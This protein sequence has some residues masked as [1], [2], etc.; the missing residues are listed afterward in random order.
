MAG[1]HDHARDAA[2]ATVAKRKLALTVS[3]DESDRQ[4]SGSASRQTG[5]LLAASTDSDSA[6]KEGC[7]GAGREIPVP[8]VE[9]VSEE[10]DGAAGSRRRDRSPARTL[11]SLSL[12]LSPAGDLPIRPRQSGVRSHP[13]A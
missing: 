3:G 8:S 4:L 12:S 6:R 1:D 7:L 11:R 5:A 9:Q 13:R 10:A 2:T